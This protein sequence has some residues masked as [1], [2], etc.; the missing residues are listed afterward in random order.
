MTTTPSA[1]TVTESGI[2]LRQRIEAGRHVLVADEAREAGGGDAGPDPYS[3]LLAALG[4]CTSMT[5][6][7]YA[8]RKGWPLEGVSVRLDHERVYE[9]DCAEC[10]TADGR[11]S[12]IRRIVT[13]SGPLSEEQRA[14]LLEIAE[15]C[16][17]H[18]T[19][20]GPVRIETTLGKA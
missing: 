5:L 6:R 11:L 8:D 10:E 4:A 20:A 17:V 1:V 18:R 2:R 12:R 3:L 15:R 14:R 7:L 19:L 16:P 13:L 9:R